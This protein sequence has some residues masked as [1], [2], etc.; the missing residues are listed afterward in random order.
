MSS[1]FVGIGWCDSSSVVVTGWC[2]SS[3]LLSSLHNEACPQLSYFS[4]YT[5]SVSLLAPPFCLFFCESNWEQ[6]VFFIYT[7]DIFVGLGLVAFPTSDVDISRFANVAIKQI[8][9]VHRVNV[10]ARS[11]VAFWGIS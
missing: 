8:Y 10:I 3:S 5:I 9:V 4:W 2:D 11:I 1:T 7:V 6:F